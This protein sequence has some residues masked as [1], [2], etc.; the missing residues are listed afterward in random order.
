MVGRSDV[1]LE[2]PVPRVITATPQGCFGRAVRVA[3]I[4]VTLSRVELLAL[5]ELLDTIDL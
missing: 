2:L 4:R 3:G 5:K 1:K